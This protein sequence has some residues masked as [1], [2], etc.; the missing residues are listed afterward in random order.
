ML[1]ASLP[2][3]KTLLTLY[4]IPKPF[5]SYALAT[6][7]KLATNA[8]VCAFADKGVCQNADTTSKLSSFSS[9]YRCV[10]W[11]LFVDLGLN[12]NLEIKQSLLPTTFTILPHF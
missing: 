3:F 8:L 6:D 12:P 5:I 7:N 10:K 4:Q 11:V 9:Q 2:A 1:P